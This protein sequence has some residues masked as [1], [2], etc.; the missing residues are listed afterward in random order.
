MWGIK[1]KLSISKLSFWLHSLHEEAGQR[2]QQTWTQGTG[3]KVCEL[4]WRRQRIP[5]KRT[6]HTK[7]CGSSRCDYQGVRS[8]L[9]PWQHRDARPT[10]WGVT[11]TGN[12][13]PRWWS[14]RRWQQ[15]GAGHIYC[16]KGRV[17]WRR[18]R[19]HSR[20]NT[21]TRC[22]RCWGSSTGWRIYCN[23][24]ESQRLWITG[25]QWN[26]GLLTDS[27]LLWR[28]TGASGQGR[29]QT[30]D[31]SKESSAIFWRSQDPSCCDW[32]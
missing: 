28:S 21:E 5:G 32:G 26:G 18:E 29:A 1:P 12:L 31:T 2:C 3:R 23:K 14:S 27:W 8:G 10:R 25:T 11:A 20:S 24:R 13:A 15:R 7:S 19:E 17:A 6:Q 22:L 16:N 30:R 4:H 9:N